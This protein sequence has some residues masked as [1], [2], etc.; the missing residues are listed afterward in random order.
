MTPAAKS[1]VKS[2][3]LFS[4]ALVEEMPSIKDIASVDKHIRFEVPEIDELAKELKQ[5]PGTHSVVQHTAGKKGEH[6][7]LHVFYRNPKER[8][9]KM[10]AVRDRIKKAPASPIMNSLYGNSQISIRAHDSYDN[11][12]KYVCENP[13]HTVLH[14]PPDLFQKSEEIKKGSVLNLPLLAQQVGVS[15]KVV[16]VKDKKK[17]MRERFINYLENEIKWEKNRTINLSNYDSKITEIIRHL[18]DF[19]ENAFTFPEGSRMLEHARYVFADDDIREKIFNDNIYSLKKG[20]R[21]N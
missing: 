2:L 4:P 9:E 20:L 1:K 13:S 12:V 15:G 11:W 10:A 17:P 3:K 7:H 8:P 14:G 18:T 19:W 16:V 5:F 21:G 6:P